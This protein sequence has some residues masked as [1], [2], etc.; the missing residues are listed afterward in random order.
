M[1]VLFMV[2][3]YIL[4]FL[5]IIV[6]NVFELFVVILLIFK[7]VF[8]LDFVFGGLIGMVIFW[9][10]K[11]GIYLNEVGQGIGLYLVVVVEVFYLVK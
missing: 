2:I 5:I 7:S 6:M 1:I 4:L 8:V 10:V 3:G 11:C 9:G